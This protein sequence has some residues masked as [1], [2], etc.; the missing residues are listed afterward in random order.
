MTSFVTLFPIGF[1]FTHHIS[2]DSYGLWD[3]IQVYFSSSMHNCLV[4]HLGMRTEYMP[5]FFTNEKCSKLRGLTL[6]RRFFLLHSS[7][8]AMMI[9][10]PFE[11]TRDSEDTDKAWC[12][13][14]NHEAFNHPKLSRPISEQKHSQKKNML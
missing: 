7:I 11:K 6:T 1:A 5:T 9:T 10:L 8:N 12:Q 3:K 2:N 14:L 13:I 4:S